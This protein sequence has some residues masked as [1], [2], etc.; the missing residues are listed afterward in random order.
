MLVAAG[1]SLLG[2]LSALRAEERTT[3]PHVEG[4]VWQPDYATIDPRGK[5]D[6]L[7][8]RQL[9]VQWT[10]VD[11]LSFV[12]SS[13]LKPAAKIPDWTRISREPWAQEVILGLATLYDESS[14][15]RQ[16]AELA[17]ISQR[18]AAL[19]TP[20]K[21]VGW[22]FPVEVDPTWTDAPRLAAILQGLP[23]PLWVSVYDNSNIGPGPLSDWLTTWLPADI[24]VF[25]QDGVGV[26]AREA[27]VA[28]LYADVL[29]E[30]LGH[31]RLRII[32]EGFRPQV[33]GGFRPA[34]VPEL[35]PQLDAYGGHRLFLFEGPHYINDAMVCALSRPSAGDR[36]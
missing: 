32:V 12:L 5:W 13:E 22:Y 31:D 18:V 27:R 8:A 7:G 30:R 26:H 28:R 17:D 23:K 19:L 4:I 6:R 9:L 35:R 1:A 36:C 29:A 24:S 33:G 11:G 15:R 3:Q 16:L 21:I 10:V 34:T 25:F 20:L 2:P 14:A